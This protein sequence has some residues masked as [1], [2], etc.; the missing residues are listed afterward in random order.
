[1]A[2]LINDGYADSLPYAILVRLYRFFFV[3]RV[4]FL[5][6]E[7]L[8]IY[9]LLLLRFCFCLLST[10]VLFLFYSIT[11]FTGFSTCITMR[12]SNT[13][14]NVFVLFSFFRAPVILKIMSL[15]CHYFHLTVS[16]DHS[17]TVDFSFISSG[18]R[19]SPIIGR[20]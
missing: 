14:E 8:P 15:I 9:I 19:I 2:S 10:G 18:Q 1:M 11:Q 20:L 13:S 12:T 3:F 17:V 6:S 16:F 5:L 4:N 7:Y